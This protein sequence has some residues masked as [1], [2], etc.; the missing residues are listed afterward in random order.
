MPDIPNPFSPLDNLFITSKRHANASIPTKPWADKLNPLKKLFGK[1][2]EATK[3]E[4]KSE[5]SSS[6]TGLENVPQLLGKAKRA[7]FKISWA[8]NDEEIK[9]AQRL[10]YKV[11]A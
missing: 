5:T 10:R 7:P 4:T 2:A 11:F 3:G 8:I 9:E 6:K 1:K